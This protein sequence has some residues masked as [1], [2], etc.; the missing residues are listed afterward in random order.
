MEYIEM[1]E[2]S[3]I[4]LLMKRFNYFHDSCIKELK[5]C[6]GGY[7]DE[8]G[9]MYPFNSSRCVEM[10]CQ[11]QNA[12]IR[13]IEIKFEGVHQLNLV[14]RDEN[15]DC[16]I[17]GASLKKMD[18]LYYWSEWENLNAEDLERGGGTWI[19]AETVSWRSLNNA[20]GSKKIY[21]KLEKL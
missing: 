11:S 14:P 1:R 12:V 13:V 9:S 3:D 6:S 20:F 7:V 18:E 5:Y 10:I 2:Q 19:S 8:D 17:H 4:E 15:Y 21:N 16:V